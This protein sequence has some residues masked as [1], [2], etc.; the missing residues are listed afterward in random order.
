MLEFRRKQ[1]LSLGGIGIVGTELNED[2]RHIV[3]R[4]PDYNLKKIPSD[5][6]FF[7]QIPRGLRIKL[8]GKHK[9]ESFLS[10]HG[11]LF[12]SVPWERLVHL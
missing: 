11:T 4:H 3:V 2:Y 8:G 7:N 5:L 12:V 10:P 1:P 6:G 9:P